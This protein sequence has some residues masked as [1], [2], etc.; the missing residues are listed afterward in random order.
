MNN[1]LFFRCY[2]GPYTS[3]TKKNNNKSIREMN[4]SIGIPSIIFEF[5]LLE[6]N[7][8]KAPNVRI[9]CTFNDRAIFR[10]RENKLIIFTDYYYCNR[11]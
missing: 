5:I 10:C 9:P 6:K 2:Q 11:Q 4:G 1:E 8:V 7:D 3:K